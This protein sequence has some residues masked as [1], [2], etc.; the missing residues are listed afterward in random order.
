MSPISYDKL[1]ES[2]LVVDQVYEGGTKGN[3]GDDPVCRVLPGIGNQSGFRA[4][5]RGPN[6]RF[7]VLFSMG[8]HPDWPDTIH[9]SSG[10]F[11]Y[12]GDNRTPG[13]ELH[14][15]SKRGNV[16]LRDVFENLHSP[17]PQREMIPPF[18]V[19]TRFPTANSRHSV[20]FRGLAVPGY[21]GIPATEDLM[22][23]WKTTNGQ[24]FQNYRA[25]FTILDVPKVDREW[26]T[27][28]SKS[29]PLSNN[30]PP[31]WRDWIEKGVY[32]PLEAPPTTKIRTVEEQ[33]PQNELQRR[34][35]RVIWNHFK[36]ADRQFEYFA[37]Y[38]FSLVDQRVQIDDVTRRSSDG[39]RD[40]VGRYL[41]G[42]KA[43]PV[44][45]EFS[46]EAK[47]Y[48]PGLDGENRT[49]VGVKELARLISRLRH[50]QFGVLVTT[51][52][53]GRQAYSEIREDRHPIIVI[54][55]NDLSQI[56]IDKGY[57]TEGLMADLLSNRFPV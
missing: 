57:S 52:A 51:S 53:V 19:F 46:L 27:D 16:L 29:N 4:A 34:I 2:D 32:R 54:S 33:E 15:T 48:C 42:L 25:E 49:T 10:R 36:Q 21:P 20:Q 9:L 55:G 50:R 44:F 40:A 30:A 18:L 8:D 31:V 39:G 14:D 47:C 41:F 13:K 12:Y 26:I 45:A 17:M 5:G 24:R 37:A 56:L 35:L 11:T 6:K 1:S 43:D 3:A 23:V 28:L 7:V 22:A 38:V